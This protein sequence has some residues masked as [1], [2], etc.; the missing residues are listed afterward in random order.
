MNLLKKIKDQMIM[1]NNQVIIPVT[2]NPPLPTSAGSKFVA[3]HVMGGWGFGRLKGTGKVHPR[4]GHE[5]P[6]GEYR[7]I[8]LYSFLNLS[9]RLGWVVNTTPRPI[10]PRERPG[11][12]SI[13]GWVGPRAGLDGCGKSFPHWDLMPRPSRP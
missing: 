11:T 10:Y 2:I 7:Y 13:G 9:T 12:Q 6:E 3:N 4:K 1:K 8:Y 5:G